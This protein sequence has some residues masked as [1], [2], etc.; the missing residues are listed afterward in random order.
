MSDPGAL[1]DRYCKYLEWLGGRLLT[2][3][4]RTLTNH[5]SRWCVDTDQGPVEA[6]SAV[7]ALGPWAG[8]V[9]AQLGYRLRVA[10]ERGYHMHYAP[11]GDAILHRP[12]LDAER[13]YFITPM[14]RGIR[15]TTGVEFANRDAPKTPVQL[16]RA[17]RVARSLFPLNHRLDA[18]PWMGCRPCTP[19][20]MPVI[21]P[22][23]NHKNLW[24]AFGHAHHGLTLGAVTGRLISE[25]IVGE[26]PLVNMA[27]FRVD[28]P[29]LR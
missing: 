17:E 13:G 6:S 19:D 24:F 18:E 9:T 7:V 16:E 10:V 28:R 26:K 23:P 12:V 5:G 2:G 8:V 11:R 4:A 21:G 1:I 14:A 25:M 29:Q 3:N 20:M 27:P 22:A 15:L